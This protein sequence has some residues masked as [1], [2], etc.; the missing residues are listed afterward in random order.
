MFCQHCGVEVT[1]DLNY[2]KRCGGGL[3][4]QELA[5]RA[6]VSPFTVWGI[7]TTTVFLVVGGLAVLFAF[8]FGL[9]R[10]G[11]LPAPAITMLAVLGTLTILGSTALMMRLWRFLLAG[12]HAQ[13]PARPAQ[14]PRP[15]AASELPPPRARAL[16][17]AFDPVPSVTE[18][19]TRTFDPAYREPRQR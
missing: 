18:H 6:S 9:A 3:N 13:T 19:T 4:P 10:R 1:H 11:D 12:P 17:E 14:L 5:P 7:G 2:C 16:P 8:I 15:S